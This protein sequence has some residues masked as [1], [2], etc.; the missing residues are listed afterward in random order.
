ME[1]SFK[2]NISKTRQYF[3]NLA[4]S[5]LFICRFR[6]I[7][8]LQ[9]LLELTNKCPFELYFLNGKNTFYYIVSKGTKLCEKT[10]IF[11]SIYSFV[12]LFHNKFIYF[13]CFVV[14]FLRIYIF[15]HSTVPELT[16]QE[17]I[18]NVRCIFW[19]MLEALCVM[20]AF[21]TFETKIFLAD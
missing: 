3:N 9:H 18:V 15:P 21:F 17:N 12:L 7:L 4:H 11:I 20:Q 16:D 14:V 6:R 2:C 1:N 10:T 19:D 8:Q 5:L 13:D